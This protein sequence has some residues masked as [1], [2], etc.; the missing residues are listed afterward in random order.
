MRTLLLLNQ[1]YRQTILFSSHITTDI[2][3]VAADVAILDKGKIV[4]H[5]DLDDLKEQIQCLY[6]KADAAPDH[7]AFDGFVSKRIDGNRLQVWVRDWDTQKT[8]QLSE[9]LGA[10][11]HM[12]SVGL[13]ELFMGITS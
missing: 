8:K 7:L 2:E 3:R 9:Q 6:L 10:P 5:G 12:D 13:E 1:E 4:Y 11:V